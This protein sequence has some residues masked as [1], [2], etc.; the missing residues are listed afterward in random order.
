MNDR[1]RTI[2]T[3][4]PEL[5]DLNSMIRFLLH[6]N[7][8]RVAGLIYA[9]SRFHWRGDGTG[10][11]FFHDDREYDEPQTS[12][13]WKQGERFIDDAIDAYALVHAN[14]AVHDPG[15]PT[16][17]ALRAVVREGNVDFE[18]DYSRETPGSKL[19]AEALLD[20]DPEPIHLQMWAGTSTVARAL[21]SIEERFAESADWPEVHARISRK[22]IITK[23][24][25]QDDTYDGYIRPNWPDIRVT[26]IMGMGWGYIIRRVVLPADA[27]M[28]GAEWMRELVTS[29]GPLGQL[30]RVWGDGRQMV[31]GDYTDY[32][33]LSGFTA[34]ELTEQGYR[35]WLPPQGAGEWIS[36]GDTPNMLNLVGN[37]LRGHEHPSFGGWAGR[38]TR[39]DEGPDT[40][41]TRDSTDQADDGTMP[42]EYSSMRWFGD[43]PA[44]LR[45]PP[46]VVGDAAVRRRKSPSDRLRRSGTRS[47][48]RARRPDRAVGHGRRSR[49]RRPDLSLVALPG[50]RQLS[51]L[52][53]AGGNGRSPSRADRARRRGAR[54]DDP[55]RPASRGLR[56]HAARQLC[57]RGAHRRLIGCC[58]RSVPRSPGEVREVGD[59]QHTGERRGC[60][61]DG[62]GPGSR[63]VGLVARDGG[64]YREGGDQ[65]AAQRVSEKQDDRD[66][67][68]YGLP[69]PE[70]CERDQS[71]DGQQSADRPG[72]Q[73]QR[74]SGKGR[75]ASD[76]AGGQSVQSEDAE[77]HRSDKA[78]AHG[79]PRRGTSSTERE[80]E[81]HDPRRQH[82]ERDAQ[83]LGSSA[84]RLPRV[85]GKEV[86]EQM[87]LDESIRAGP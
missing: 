61:D 55:H 40:W 42:Q 16:P 11:A 66:R 12:F 3:A 45:H 2:V 83:E 77:R 59:E 5:D 87:I 43:R 65:I 54:A 17:E 13:R 33:H 53:F 37:G 6:S 10:T 22:A 18:G 30:Y 23:F 85:R 74:E 64:S 79:E 69:H 81:G 75:G 73:L 41:S 20:D 35:V 86:V 60:P 78:G 46:A 52:G 76:Q 9:S 7:E 58:I 80:G 67:H 31:P 62:P 39:T 4:D 36:E 63:V 38:G 68:G 72:N 44:R 29:V 27:H 14:L 49:R 57:A 51:P 1:P 71:D 26:D 24:A 82:Q 50:S 47:T 19:I 34:D 8:L 84:D 70:N 32:F 25:S 56:C 48:G 28:L 21:L 15:Y